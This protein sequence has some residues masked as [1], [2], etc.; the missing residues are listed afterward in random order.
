MQELLEMR[1]WNG[2]G[3][4]KW[5]LLL[6]VLFMRFCL[7]FSSSPSFISVVEPVS[8]VLTLMPEL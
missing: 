2:A 7:G 1:N 5:G 6:L 4:S 8:L 3:S